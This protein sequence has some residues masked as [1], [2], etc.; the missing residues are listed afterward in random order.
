M[1]VA[2]APVRESKGLLTGESVTADTRRRIRDILESDSDVKSVSAPLTM[3]FGR[4][5]VLLAVDIRFREGLSGNGIG[6]AVERL[7]SAVRSEYPPKW[8]RSAIGVRCR[9]RSSAKTPSEN[10]QS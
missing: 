7:E 10:S 3:Y 1:A 5:T 9:F 2:L 6:W 4:E 8:H